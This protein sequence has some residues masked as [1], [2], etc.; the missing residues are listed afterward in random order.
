VNLPSERL[1]DEVE[2]VDDC[3]QVCQASSPEVHELATH[4]L[5]GLLE[6]EGVRGYRIKEAA[7]SS[8]SVSASRSKR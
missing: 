4:T 5:M 3:T 6:F 1:F 8:A 7:E 2:R